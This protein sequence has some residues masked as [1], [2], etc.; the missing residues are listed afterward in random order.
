VPPLVSEKDFSNK[1]REDFFQALLQMS[2]TRALSQT[3][4]VAVNVERMR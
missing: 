1:W 3:N 4:L 2:R